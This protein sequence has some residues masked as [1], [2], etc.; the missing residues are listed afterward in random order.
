[1]ASVVI[2]NDAQSYHG[3]FG[4]LSARRAAASDTLSRRQLVGAGII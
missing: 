3:R 4:A 1:M 2:W